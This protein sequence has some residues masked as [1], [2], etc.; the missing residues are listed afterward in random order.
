MEFSRIP[1][2]SGNSVSDGE[3]KAM[4]RMRMLES[5]SSLRVKRRADEGVVVWKG[6]NFAKDDTLRRISF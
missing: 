2:F 1:D 3:M 4:Y 5:L 6:M